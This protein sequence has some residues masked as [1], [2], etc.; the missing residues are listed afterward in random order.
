VLGEL[1]LHI[2]RNFIES[3]HLD[4]LQHTLPAFRVCV[5]VEALDPVEN[6]TAP[7]REHLG[8]DFGSSRLLT[9]NNSRASAGLVAG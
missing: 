4:L 2:L 7:I 8:G 1:G 5:Q 6:G 9:C 3:L